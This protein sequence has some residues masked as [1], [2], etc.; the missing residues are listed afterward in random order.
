MRRTIEAI[1]S[2]G[3]EAVTQYFQMYEVETFQKYDYG[4]DKNVEIYG[5]DRPPTYDMSK[6][7]VPVAIFL[8]G[9]DVI[10]TKTV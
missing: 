3:A 5:T 9:R 1:D 10:S 6:V 4:K 8:G 7:S 2:T